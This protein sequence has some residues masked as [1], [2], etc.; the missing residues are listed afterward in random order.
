[1]FK[2]ILVIIIMKFEDLNNKLELEVKKDNAL[3]DIL[4]KY[5][6]I[7]DVDILALEEKEYIINKTYNFISIPNN[8]KYNAINFEIKAENNSNY[9]S[10]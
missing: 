7:E 5:E 3:I 1:M 9:I 4:Y 10:I 2:L 8:N 6:E